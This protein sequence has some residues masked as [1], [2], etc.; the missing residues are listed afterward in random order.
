M[1]GT[2]KVKSGLRRAQAV[3]LV[4]IVVNQLQ[5]NLYIQDDTLGVWPAS[6]AKKRLS[7]EM[8]LQL[9]KFRRRIIEIIEEGLEE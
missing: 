9:K 3:A 4:D 2:P 8:R 5:L 6:E 7:G 1:T